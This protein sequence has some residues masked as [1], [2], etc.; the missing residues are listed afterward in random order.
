M[1]IYKAVE[2]LQDKKKYAVMF[3]SIQEHREMYVCIFQHSIDNLVE[4]PEG[5]L[6]SA[7]G[8]HL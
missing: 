1:N 6:Y 3:E 2:F 5:V 7:R 4:Q 8:F